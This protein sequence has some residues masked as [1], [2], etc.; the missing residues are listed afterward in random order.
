MTPTQLHCAILAVRPDSHFFFFF[1][2]KFFGDTMS[3]YGVRSHDANTWE[4]YRK[5]PVKYGLKQSTYFD[6]QT[7]IIVFPKDVDN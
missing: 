5:K 2:M 7:L 6:K 4:L 3:N 1:T